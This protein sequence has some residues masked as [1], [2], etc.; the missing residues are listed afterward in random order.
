MRPLR[1]IRPP[2]TR[3]RRLGQHLDGF[4]EPP[5]L[6][7]HDRQRVLLS[8]RGARG[9]SFAI[10]QR[11]GSSP[12]ASP[13]STCPCSHSSRPI[14][15]RSGVPGP[16][17]RARSYS[18][19]CLAPGGRA[20]PRGSSLPVRPRPS[21]TRARSSGVRS[22]SGTSRSN[23]AQA[24]IASS[25]GSR[26]QS[27]RPGRASPGRKPR[28]RSVG[29]S[30]RQPARPG[31]ACAAGRAARS[32]T[33]AGTRPTA[34]PS[35]AA[36]RAR[37]VL[38]PVP[39]VELRCQR[40]RPR[41]QLLGELHRPA[42]P[43]P[44]AAGSAGPR[45][46]GST[47][48]MRPPRSPS[49]PAARRVGQLGQVPLDQLDSLELVAGS[50]QKLDV[51]GVRAQLTGPV[52]QQPVRP[53]VRVDSLGVHALGNISRQQRGEHLLRL[54]GAGQLPVQHARPPARP[55][56]QSGR[57][58]S[59]AAPS[60]VGSQP[61]QSDRSSRGAV[62]HSRNCSAAVSSSPMWCGDQPAVLVHRVHAVPAE[63]PPPLHVVQYG[64]RRGPAAPRG[65]WSACWART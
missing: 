10:S 40:Q 63:P 19:Q 55:R 29:Y 53:P 30:R 46:P 43:P 52:P 4:L 60:S 20:R 2:V 26:C 17:R 22:L 25:R 58:R 65:T 27:P 38:R 48:A 9:S 14:R 3:R 1:S 24:A 28:R 51:V 37:S 59:G 39:L 12:V 36:G 33:A 57:A 6:R 8:R 61:T 5:D 42:R 34:R 49:P 44:A 41:R 64:V 13:S 21:S 7:V 50:G 11:S 47:R 23:A 54:L 18:G 16:P 56:Q 15:P 35:A 32:P 45:P 62:D 31:P